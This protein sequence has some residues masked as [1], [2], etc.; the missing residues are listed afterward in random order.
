MK[1]HHT[2]FY[3]PST[4]ENNEEIIQHFEEKQVSMQ[5]IQ[6]AL[7]RHTRFVLTEDSTETTL[8]M[9]INA[10]KGVLKESN[11]SIEEIDAIVFV[12]TTPEHRIPNDAIKIHH[13]L[14]GK[15]NTLCYDINVNCIGAFVALD[16]AC[17]Y[18]T[19]T[20]SAQNAL[21]I[22]AEKLSNILDRENPVTAFCF[23]DSAFAFIVEKDFSASGLIDVLYHTD[24]TFSEAVL[25]PPKG[26]S[27]YHTDDLTLWDTSFD[28][29]G[30]VDFALN[31]I[32]EF[33]KRNELSIEQIDLFLFSQ[34]SIKNINK[35]RDHFHLPEEKIPFCSKELG[36]TGAS[37]PFLAL[38]QYQKN[39]RQLEKGEYVL[40]WTLGAGYQA[41][42]ML[43]KY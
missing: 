29:S 28:G 40:I 25:F 38:D 31:H 13:A 36:Y 11:I 23:S 32:E 26:Y 9:G 37:S 21:I 42:L 30:S 41:G 20:Q 2:F 17:K 15:T 1:L 7:G 22:C 33:L 24:S 16:L 19:G 10:A 6:D 18:L 14:G 39:T 3:S 4:M 5:K 27:C 35:I 34:L 12:S 8:T 43:W